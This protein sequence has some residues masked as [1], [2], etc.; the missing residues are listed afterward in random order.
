M[1]SAGPEWTLPSIIYLRPLAGDLIQLLFHDPGAWGQCGVSEC[2][3]LTSLPFGNEF[4]QFLSVRIDERLDM[5]RIYPRHDHI[6]H[7]RV[8]L[9]VDSQRLHS[10]SL[11]QV[12][13]GRTDVM[14]R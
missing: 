1:L 11:L 5:F 14:D 13:L 7:L 9:V 12:V 8:D 4:F 2:S 10:L 3:G 6:S